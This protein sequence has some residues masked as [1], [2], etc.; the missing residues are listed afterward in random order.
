MELFNLVFQLYIN[1]KS[2]P[3]L[4]TP[5]MSRKAVL[6]KHHTGHMFT[7]HALVHFFLHVSKQF[8]QSTSLS[9]FRANKAANKNSLKFLSSESLLL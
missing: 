9:L 4:E 8:C 1:N 2:K 5:V 3:C 7:Q 6:H